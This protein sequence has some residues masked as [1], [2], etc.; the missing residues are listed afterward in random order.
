LGRKICSTVCLLV[1]RNYVAH[2][3]DKEWDH[4]DYDRNLIVSEESTASIFRAFKK[5]PTKIQGN[6]V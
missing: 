3:C 6:T 1:F 5:A 2:S 4:V